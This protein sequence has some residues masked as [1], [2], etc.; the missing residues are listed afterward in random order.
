MSL[1][2]T[3]GI[4]RHMIPKRERCVS[5]LLL[6]QYLIYFL[7]RD[8]YVDYIDLISLL[9]LP[10]R[11]MSAVSL[12]LTRR[13][14]STTSLLGWLTGAVASG[15]PERFV[16]LLVDFVFQSL[17]L[18]LYNLESNNYEGEI[19]YR[20]FPPSIIWCQ[21]SVRHLKFCIYKRKPYLS[22]KLEYVLFI[23]LNFRVIIDHGRWIWNR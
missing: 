17:S 13:R 19:C 22:K 14:R 3:W 12:E 7:N 21:K 8:Y 9:G 20:D 11:T 6:T 16:L 15:F 4:S 23:I 1:G 18:Y 2:I 5:C 10:L